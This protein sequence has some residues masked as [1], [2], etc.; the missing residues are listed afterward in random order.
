[1]WAWGQT[2]RWRTFL[3]GVWGGADV[4]IRAYI[5]FRAAEGAHAMLPACPECGPAEAHPLLH[6]GRTA[7]ELCEDPDHHPGGSRYLRIE[8][9]RPHPVMHACDVVGRIAGVRKVI[10]DARARTAESGVRP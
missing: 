10:R 8:G 7:F 9:C 2:Q 6:F 1:M 3:L 4:K 5:L